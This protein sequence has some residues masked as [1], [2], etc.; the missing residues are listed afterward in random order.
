MPASN[1]LHYLSLKSRRFCGFLCGFV[2]F[3]SG[4]LKLMDPVGSG[5]IMGKYLD[6]LHI[7]FLG[8]AAKGLGVLFALVETTIGAALVT[9][10]WRKVTAIA[11]LSLQVFFTFLTL[12]LVIFNPTMDCGCFG[13]AIHLTHLQTFIKNIAICILLAI[14]F[15]PMRNLG[16]PAK[17]KFVSF[18]LVSVSVLAF[19][20]YSLFYLPFVDFTDFKP[21]VGLTAAKPEAENAYESV[22]TY[23]K[24][25]VQKEFS[26]NNLPDSTWSFVSTQTILKNE[27]STSGATLSIYD[28]DGNYLDSLAVQNNVMI[29]SAYDPQMREKKWNA[30]V[31]FAQEAQ[32]AGFS[33]MILVAGTPEQ[34]SRIQTGGIPLYYCDY[35]TLITMNRSNGGATWFSKGYLIKKWS[36]RTYPD[37]SALEKYRKGNTTESVLENDAEGSLIFQGFLLYVF[38]VMLLL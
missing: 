14:A 1:F 15:I 11:A 4:I 20:I 30:A 25:G 3:I 28:K 34:T 2:F 12:L 13:E 21:G 23:E 36:S 35:K 9:G 29:I 10:I 18:G 37:L 16:R 24:D 8:F 5:L 27:P 22:F 32:K 6:F 33:P 31:K 38:A 26:L 7:G 19:T 17:R